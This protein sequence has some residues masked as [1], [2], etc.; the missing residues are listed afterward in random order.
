MRITRHLKA[1]LRRGRLDDDLREELAQH[2][3][4]KT[5]SLIAEGVPEAEARRQ[6]AVAV[7]NVMKLREEA[8]AMWGFPRLD[9]FA[10]D[11]RY[12]ARLLR[13]SPAFTL[14]AV[15]SLAIGI[16]AST[17]V[18]SLADAALLRAM[19]V[20][21]P[22]GLVVIKWRSGPVL[23]FSSLNG[24]GEQT[25][26]GLAST[27]FSRAAY[28]SFQRN[29]SRYVDVAGFA[30]L[31][32][33]NVAL[34]GRADL[35][36]AHA[37]SGNYFD[38][39]GVTPAS[40]RGLGAADDRADAAGAAVIS[41]RLWRTRFGG[42]P[43]AVGKTMLINL[44]PFTIVGVAPSS[45]H[46]TGQVGT[47][48]DIFVPL[49]LHARVM[50][51]DD[52]L[53][54]PNFWWVLMMG[55]LQPGVT[56]DQARAALDVL[57]KRTVA[58]AKPALGAKDYPRVDLLPGG[59][60]QVEAREDMRDPLQ[61]MGL[62]A[63]VVL[64]V[65]CANVASLLLARG[66]AR[67]RELSI[68]VA[69]GAPRRRV[70]RQLLT[71]A[72][73]IGLAGGALGV[74]A[75]HWMSLALAP[76]L[77]TSSE[78]A[79]LVVQIDLRVMAFAVVTSCACAALFGVIPA[80][81]ATDVTVGVRLQE[82]GR[83]A[84]RSDRHRLLPGALVVTQIALALLLV[85]SAGLLI[86]TVRNLESVDLGF[87]AANLLLFRIDPSL[88]GYG[89]V[90]TADLYA[91]VL[92][93]LRS[94]PGVVAASLSSQKLISN[95]AAVGV[96]ARSDEAAPQ[97][98]SGE[99]QIFAKAHRG[100]SLTVDEH[101]FQTMGIRVVR[102]RSFAPGDEG[103]PPSVVINR[104]LARQ[105]FGTGEAV[106]RQLRFGSTK[107]AGSEMQIIGVV[108][109][110]RYSSMR[111]DKP[112]TMYV[113]YR[114]PPPMKNAATF[115]V[116]TAGP[117]STFAASVRAIVRE[118]D[119]A[120]PVFGVM[121][122]SDQIATSLRQERLFA[123]LATLL[124]AVAILLSAI[125]LYGLLAYGVARRTAEIGLRMALGA[126]RASVVWMVLRESLVLAGIGLLLGVPAALAGTRVLQS[127]L[128]GL[129]P[130]DPVTTLTVAALAMV[131]LAA[132]AGYVPARRAA[133]VDPLVALRAE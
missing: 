91:R 29:A 96:V 11:L 3:R 45:F 75:A 67:V 1:W 33:V 48:P 119:P 117:P 124:G 94:A 126:A 57:L 28:L 25:T 9:G 23:P 59:R 95:S 114:H 130:R 37:V 132:V 85:A 30:D 72:L 20:R 31:Y 120:L 34:D 46:G 103:G 122:Q 71:E 6:A 54:D 115:E 17:A 74:V 76:A 10:Q 55:R 58:A 102:G 36:T 8:R 127:M 24:S 107:R 52:P 110:A 21:D 68:R 100:W 70:V 83:G 73:L 129:A 116:R 44:A 51:N 123:R 79:D 26:D 109:D 7:G 105:L 78:P 38:V 90:Q 35:A 104:L 14:V 133:R 5:D 15:A 47:D 2:I 113:Y 121:T 66:R 86:R 118:F 87:D 81:R 42:D 92:E 43:G 64:L 50:P 63:L 106:G 93:R 56:L 80:L 49:A 16:G 27:S 22:G 39:L 111:D 32:Q 12:G 65:A 61:T 62:V 99:M 131:L 112:P 4:W 89:G 19:A 60:G 18:F 84:G 82:A 128:F 69:I 98:A 125:G 53:D 41:D 88:N 77:S 40:G 108:E 13:K 97:P 101:F